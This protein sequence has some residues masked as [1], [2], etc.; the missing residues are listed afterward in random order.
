M[1]LAFLKLLHVIKNKLE[2]GNN[3]GNKASRDAVLGGQREKHIGSIIWKKWGDILTWSRP[4]HGGISIAQI[5]KYYI[6]TVE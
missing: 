2:C 5:F 1:P 4:I 3:Y 6:L